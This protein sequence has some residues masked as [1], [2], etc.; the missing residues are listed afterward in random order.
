MVASAWLTESQ[1]SSADGLT[2]KGN[3]EC[4]M[5]HHQKQLTVAKSAFVKANIQAGTVVVF[6][7]LT[8]NIDSPGRV[9]LVRGSK[10]QGKITCKCLHIEEGARFGGQV[11]MDECVDPADLEYA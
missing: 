5:V 1:P 8:G 9:V 6:G 7:E 3:L 11:E 10:V 4:D 2:I